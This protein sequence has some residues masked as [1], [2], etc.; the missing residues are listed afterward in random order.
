MVAK[1]QIVICGACGKEFKSN[2]DYLDHV[3]EKTGYTPRDI[4]HQDALTGGRFSKIS[5][6]AL[7]RGEARKAKE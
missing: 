5:A 7:A 1:K 6:A 2:D 4:E 3:C